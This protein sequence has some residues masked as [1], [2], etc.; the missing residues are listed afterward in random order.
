MSA[1]APAVKRSFK[2]KLSP[3]KV[4]L[5]IVLFVFTC[6]FTV[7]HAAMLQFLEFHAYEVRGPRNMREKGNSSP[8]VVSVNVG[9]SRPLLI[10]NST[11][12]NTWANQ[13]NGEPVSGV[14]S[15]E[16]LYSYLSEM[17]R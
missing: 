17:K 14:Q 4:S 15:I 7:R 12:G 11:R 2:W 5:L 13:P 9:K 3:R 6:T 10:Y 1:G 8:R 16:P